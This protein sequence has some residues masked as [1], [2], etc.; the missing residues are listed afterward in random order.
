MYDILIGAIIL[1]IIIIICMCKK[2]SISPVLKID[3]S[4][5]NNIPRKI[6][7][8]THIDIQFV[9]DLLKCHA[10]VDFPRFRFSPEDWVVISDQKP[11]RGPSIIRAKTKGS[12]PFR[13]VANIPHFRTIDDRLGFD[14]DRR[15]RGHYEL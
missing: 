11:C 3:Q 12:S 8:T 4:V 15:S 5:I 14:S 9:P 7:M 13:A 1:V 10:K 6:Y 2:S